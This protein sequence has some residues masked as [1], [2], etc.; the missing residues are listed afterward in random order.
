[1]ASGKIMLL[2]NPAAGQGRGLKMLPRINNWIGKVSQQE[3]AIELF[4]TKKTGSFQATNLAYR[5]LTGNYDRIIAVGGDGTFS[6]LAQALAGSQLPLGL[7]MAGN[8]NDYAR[9]LGIPKN[10]EQALAVA[11]TGR[12]ISV[13]LGQVNERIFVNMVGLGF[14]AQVAKLAEEQKKHWQFMPRTL[15]Y[16]LALLRLLIFQLRFPDL[17]ISF[18]QTGNLSVPMITGKITLLA[19]ANGQ[20]C[21]GVF[22]MAPQ[23]KLTD[24]LFDICRISQASRLRILKCLPAIFN[25]SHLKLPE[26]LTVAGGLPQTSWLVVSSL[27][28]QPIACHLDG[29]IM[30][31]GKQY[32]FKI[33]P[34]ALKVVVP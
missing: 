11:L 28:N 24:G 14:D 32:V 23:A 16:L 31:A 4:L 10:L 15:L 34:Q 30:P 27:D 7:V 2:V 8:G 33:L 17:F 22:R 13:D 3:L 12:V 1:M 21:G 25:G 6:E 5:A 20:T 29:E 9:A 18:D 19:I 26:V